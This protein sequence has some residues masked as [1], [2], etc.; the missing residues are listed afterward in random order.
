MVLLLTLVVVED[1]VVEDS[2]VDVTDVMLIVMVLLLT[3]LK[4]PMWS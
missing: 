1:T 3:W 2:V 4:T